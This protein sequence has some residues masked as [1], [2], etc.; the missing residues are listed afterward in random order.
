MPEMVLSSFLLGMK[1][2]WVGFAFSPWCLGPVSLMA[3]YV[4][5]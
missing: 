4:F 2:P 1:V 3:V 5:P